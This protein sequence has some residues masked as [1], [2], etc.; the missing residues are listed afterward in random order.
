MNIEKDFEYWVD[1]LIEE[2]YDLS[3]YTWDEIYEEYLTEKGVILPGQSKASPLVKTLLSSPDSS[4]YK[5]GFRGVSFT[6]NTRTSPTQFIGQGGFAASASRESNPETRAFLT[7]LSR[8]AHASDPGQRIRYGTATGRQVKSSEG[9]PI[10]MAR[11]AASAASSGTS[12]QNAPQRAVTLNKGYAAKLGGKDVNVVYKNIGGKIQR[13]T[14]SKDNNKVLKTEDFEYWVDSLFEEGYD[15]SNY[16]WEG[17]F[18]YF[19]ENVSNRF[20]TRN[21]EDYFG[22]TNS[23]PRPAAPPPPATQANPMDPFTAGGGFAK[24]KSGMS[25]S[26]V[27]ALGT[28]NLARLNSSSKQ[29]PIPANASSAKT[30]LPDQIKQGLGVYSRQ[31]QMKDYKG[32]DTTGRALWAAKYKDTLAKNVNSDG[33]QKPQNPSN[34]MS[35]SALNLRN[36]RANLTTSTPSGTDVNSRGGLNS[37]T[38][39]GSAADQK[40]RLGERPRLQPSST[41]NP[42]SRSSVFNR[43]RL[44]LDVASFDFSS[45]SK[46]ASDMAYLYQS[47]YEGKKKVDQDM[48]GDNDFADVMIARMVAAG[49]PRAEAIRRVRNKE[50]NV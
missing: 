12:L 8:T 34:S 7:A 23:P 1:S 13:Q 3:D 29:E 31:R 22:R 20:N 37:G 41:S 48:D 18:E 35:A 5:G 30:P 50:Y 17:L 38:P 27:E 10:A 33:T 36:L 47:I 46:V 26:Q 39:T 45:P 44:R 21:W 49:V 32:A 14:I 43:E 6:K 42:Q 19:C 15:L 25:R 11:T 24:M 28:K 9:E 4:K 2:G 40:A 16:T